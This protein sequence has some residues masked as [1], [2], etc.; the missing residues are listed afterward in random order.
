[1][2][3]TRASKERAFAAE[4]RHT[5]VRA[6][7][8]RR[9]KEAGAETSAWREWISTSQPQQLQKGAN[10]LTY[11]LWTSLWFGKNCF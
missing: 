3:I 4:H 7:A 1:M 2:W 9:V 10:L 11:T 8:A 6:P 5:A